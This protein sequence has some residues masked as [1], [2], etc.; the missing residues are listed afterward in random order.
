MFIV[1][2]NDAESSGIGLLVVVLIYLSMMLGSL[3]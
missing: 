1:M 3:I 2:F